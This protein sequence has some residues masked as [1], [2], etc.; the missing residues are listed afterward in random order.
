MRVLRNFPQACNCEEGHKLMAAIAMCIAYTH[1]NIKPNK[2]AIFKIF[3]VIAKMCWFFFNYFKCDMG[4]DPLMGKGEDRR[5]KQT[6]CIFLCINQI[7]AHAFLGTFV[8]YPFAG[9]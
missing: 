5:N 8:Y 4:S 6:Q 3:S 9:V 2:N 7:I 1:Q